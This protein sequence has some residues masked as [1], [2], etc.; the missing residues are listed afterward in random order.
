VRNLVKIYG[1]NWKQHYDLSVR[2]NN[3]PQPNSNSH[4]MSMGGNEVIPLSCCRRYGREID[5]PSYHT[6][7]SRKQ[8]VL[9]NKMEAMTK[10]YDGSEDGSESAESPLLIPFLPHVSEPLAKF[11]LNGE[12]RSYIDLYSEKTGERETSISREDHSL[13]VRSIRSWCTQTEY[14]VKSHAA[15]KSKS[16]EPL[17]KLQDD[18]KNCDPKDLGITMKKESTFSESDKENVDPCQKHTSNLLCARL[19]YGETGRFFRDNH[20]N[21][22]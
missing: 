13:Q 5:N 21:M 18:W 22:V 8:S 7:S 1:E 19:N 11:S 4:P 17:W 15:G 12:V 20:Q 3:V 14:V 6:F 16:M 2:E 9:S 10:M